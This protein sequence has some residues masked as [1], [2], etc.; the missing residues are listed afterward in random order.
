MANHTVDR[1][2]KVGGRGT[3]ERYRVIPFANH[4]VDRWAKVGGRDTV[5]RYRMNPLYQGRW[6]REREHTDYPWAWE[7]G[8]TGYPG[9]P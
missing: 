5:E 6:A 8:H 2:A 3:I 9:Y 7:R 1:R 4:M